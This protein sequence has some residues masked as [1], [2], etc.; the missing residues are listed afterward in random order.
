MYL[1]VMLLQYL[2]SMELSTPSKQRQYQVSNI[3]FDFKT[4]VELLLELGEDIQKL[5]CG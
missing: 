2:Y 5:S 4:V 1:L 3:D